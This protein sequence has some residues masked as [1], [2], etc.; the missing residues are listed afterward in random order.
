M[1]ILKRESFLLRRW[2]KVRVQAGGNSLF[3]WKFRVAKFAWT[4]DK[5]GIDFN[6]KTGAGEKG[7]S[8]P[9]PE[10]LQRDEV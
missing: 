6:E 7:Y 3:L 9:V 8:L 1:R 5:F 2:Y 10:A 4:Q